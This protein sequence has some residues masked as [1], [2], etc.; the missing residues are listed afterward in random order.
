M[1]KVIDPVDNISTALPTLSSTSAYPHSNYKYY[2]RKTASPSIM[3][4]NTALLT[5]LLASF[6]AGLETSNGPLTAEA[7]AAKLVQCVDELKDSPRW[8]GDGYKRGNH[9]FYL[10]GN[11]HWEIP[12]DCIGDKCA[13]FLLSAAVKGAKWAECHQKK[14]AAE[15]WVGWK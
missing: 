2:Q 8:E 4:F 9:H 6:V 1:Y 11:G 7:D 5:A 13:Y 10:K 15:C 14:T 3:Q 12:K